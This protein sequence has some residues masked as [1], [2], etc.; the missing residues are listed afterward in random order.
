MLQEGVDQCTASVIRENLVRF[1]RLP[2]VMRLPDMPNQEPQARVRVAIGRIDL[3]APSLEARFAGRIEKA[4]PA[5]REDAA[6]A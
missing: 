4:A 2:I 6:A 3:L 1:E 5:A